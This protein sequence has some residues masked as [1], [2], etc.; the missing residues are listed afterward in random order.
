[1]AVAEHLFERFPERPEGELAPMRAAV[2]NQA[3]LADAARAIDLG[4]A[5]RLGKGEEQ[6]GGRD[7]AS[8][9]ADA[10]EA[11]FGAVYLDGGW[12]PGRAVVVQVMGTHMVAPQVADNSTD[13]KTR[14]Q[15]LAA[16]R[17]DNAAPVYELQ[18]SG[19]DH[20]K[21]FVA[22][23]RI[24]GTPWGQGEGRSKKEAE[25]AA[26][27]V[28]LSVLT[29]DAVPTTTPTSGGEPTNHA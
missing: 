8:I 10:I 20:D 27:G 19:P 12:E 17:F 18:S 26:A 14:L 23:V 15:E 29:D 16:A 5:V 7:K 4:R 28:A 24:E 2:V 21:R 6:A 22:T 13:H 11:L 9:L 25:Q 1:M 3:T